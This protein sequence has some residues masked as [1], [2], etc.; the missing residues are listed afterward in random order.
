M[1]H[2][3]ILALAAV[4]ALPFVATPI[5]ACAAEW[6]AAAIAQKAIPAVVNISIWKI[7][8]SDD[9]SVPP[10]RI[11]AYGSGFVIDPSGI[12]VTNRHVIEGALTVFITFNDGSRLPAKLIAFAPMIDI[13]VLK[14]DADHPLPV[15]T[16]GDRR[17]DARDR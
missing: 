1:K 10:P 4:F 2:F 15:L 9:P 14:V 3:V 12:I 6:T 5:P 17:S 13:A 16:W 7:K 8:L 11:K